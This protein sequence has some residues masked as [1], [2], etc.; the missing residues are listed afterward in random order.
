MESQDSPSAIKNS[1]VTENVCDRKGNRH[2]EIARFRPGNPMR[3]QELLLY[4]LLYKANSYAGA[5]LKI[6]NL[7]ENG[8]K[9]NCLDKTRCILHHQSSH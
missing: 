4:Y 7:N 9:A 1:K 8:N 2:T 5:R 6:T 3:F